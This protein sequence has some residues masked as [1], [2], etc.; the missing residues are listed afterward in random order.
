MVSQGSEAR[1]FRSVCLQPLLLQHISAPAMPLPPPPV[2]FCSAEVLFE[3]ACTLYTGRAPGVG[4]CKERHAKNGISDEKRMVRHP[5][6]VPLEWAHPL[7]RM[8][9]RV[10]A[11]RV[12]GIGCSRGRGRRQRGGRRP[13]T[14]Y[15]LRQ[16]AR[17]VSLTGS[18]GTQHNPHTQHKRTQHNLPS[19][20][21]T[22]CA[23]RCPIT[24]CVLRFRR[25]Q[26]PQACPFTP[27]LLR[28]DARNVSSRQVDGQHGSPAQPTLPPR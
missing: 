1:R 26:G 3:V 13:H 15:L 7:S 22:S 9:H 4:I 21:Y 11:V 28:Q 14:L 10:R 20:P 19:R 27:Y 23:A 24:V 2:Y 25:A 5:A 17:D 12:V 16:D 8:A 18:T 6:K